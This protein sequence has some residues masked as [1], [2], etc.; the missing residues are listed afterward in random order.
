MLQWYYM[1]YHC[2]DCTEYVKSG[3]K[4]SDETVKTLTAYFQSLFA[5]CKNNGMLERAEVDRLC[6]SAKRIIESRALRFM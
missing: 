5:Q 1:T 3:K 6:N 4:M 2:A